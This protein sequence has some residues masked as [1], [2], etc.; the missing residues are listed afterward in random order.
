MAT[1]FFDN[2][3][4]FRIAHAL[5]HLVHGHD[6]IALRDRIPANTPDLEWIPE[7][8]PKRLDCCHP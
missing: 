3:I 1:F 5:S 6:V 8:G 7:A 4:S 2:D